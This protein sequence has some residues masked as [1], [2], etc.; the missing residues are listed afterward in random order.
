MAD[1]TQFGNP[2]ALQFGD[3]ISPGGGSSG[4]SGHC[5]QCEAML[6]DALD[7]SLT[8]AAQATFDAHI[9]LC[10]PCSSMLAD[11][12][13]GAAWLEMLRDP[14]PE[15]PAGL[16]ERILAQTTAQTAAHT[17][18]QIGT[19]LGAQTA[20]HTLPHAAP[21]LLGYAPGQP[22]AWAP[23]ADPTAA[24]S[25]ASP[26]RGHVL[27]FRTRVATAVRGNFFGHAM[28]QPRLA[29]TAAMAFFSI[30][31]TLNLTG[32]RLTELRPA[33]L[34]PSSLKRGFYTANARV[35]QYYEGLR[36]VYELE[37]RV[38]DLEDE[39]GTGAGTAPTPAGRAP[40]AK[41]PE[42]SPAG[43]PDAA[44]R[45]QPRRQSPGPGSSSRESIGGP[46]RLVAIRLEHSSVRERG[47]LA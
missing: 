28:M 12:R 46:A 40:A 27:P 5:G 14:R 43:Q 20:A 19:Q 41:P 42:S 9:A 13:R 24:F 38:H 4:D 26:V 47:A 17:A 1:N 33:D 30:T 2:K 3:R 31:L 23:T 18:A 16:L 22:G 37:S 32:V 8:P 45:Q 11:A 35:V 15:P 44:P 21:A 36:V 6:A 7:G 25:P 10:R 29:M 34:K 39:S